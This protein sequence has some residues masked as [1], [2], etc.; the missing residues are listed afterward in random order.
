MAADIKESQVKLKPIPNPFISMKDPKKIS[1]LFI[2]KE[3]KRHF[4]DFE[5]QYFE[6]RIPENMESFPA[7]KYL[8]IKRLIE[9]E[10]KRAAAA[11]NH[12]VQF[13]KLRS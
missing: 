10:N 8:R 7:E 2:S 3:S 11:D 12:L 1:D 9:E 6:L 13:R 4:D 5:N